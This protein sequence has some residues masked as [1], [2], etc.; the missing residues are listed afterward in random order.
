MVN[1]TAHALLAD[2]ADADYDIELTV[3]H[4][5]ASRF[6]GQQREQASRTRMATEARYS[7]KRSAKSTAPL[8]PR[9]R[10]RK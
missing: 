2:F 9:R 7:R 5:T 6:A 4:R 3:T 10:F 1:Q 8:G